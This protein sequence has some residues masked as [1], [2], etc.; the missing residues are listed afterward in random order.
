MQQY[1][2]RHECSRYE[3]EVGSVVAIR[4]VLRTDTYTH[5]KRTVMVW[6]A[7]EDEVGTLIYLILADDVRE[8]L[9]GIVAV[10][11]LAH[12]RTSIA[13]PRSV[14]S[15]AVRTGLHLTVELLLILFDVRTEFV[16]EVLAHVRCCLKGETDVINLS[17][18]VPSYE[19]SQYVL[20]ESFNIFL[21]TCCKEELETRCLQFA[22][23]EFAFVVVPQFDG[24]LEATVRQ[25]GIEVLECT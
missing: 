11:A 4:Y 6:V 24:G 23:L 20:L 25:L 5:D 22:W 15:H 10:H 3:R 21:V 2:S 18:S 19:G 17:T 13:P 8:V 12:Y 14:C 1:E 7:A 9:V 16:E